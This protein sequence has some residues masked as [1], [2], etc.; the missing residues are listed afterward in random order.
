M[1][2]SQTL[3]SIYKTRKLIRGI[4]QAVATAANIGGAIVN[5]VSGAGQVGWAG[6]ILGAGAATSIFE[7]FDTL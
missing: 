4:N 3:F 1:V 5:I 2:L 7:I 6:A